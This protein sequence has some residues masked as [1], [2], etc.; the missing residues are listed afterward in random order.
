MHRL[1]SRWCTSTAPQ[2]HEVVKSLLR[3]PVGRGRNASTR[4]QKKSNAVARDQG[5]GPWF[6]EGLSFKC[7]GCGACCKKPAQEAVTVNAAEI[8]AIAAKLGVGEAEMLAKYVQEHPKHS[9]EP[10]CVVVLSACT[11]AC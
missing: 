6:Q 5:P 1:T 7:T 10:P 9:G 2:V 8:G 11:F 4:T 3:W